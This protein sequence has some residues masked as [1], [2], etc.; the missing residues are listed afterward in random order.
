VSTSTTRPSYTL[1]AEPGLGVRP[2]SP[3]E[4]LDAAYQGQAGAYSERAARRLCGPH[5]ALLPC[6]TLADVFLAVREGRARSGVVPIENTLTGAVPGVVSLLLSSGMVVAAEAVESIDHVLAAPPGSRLGDVRE[7][8]SHPVALAQCTRFFRSH[9]SVRAVPVFDTAGAL[10]MVMKEGASGKAAIAS[11]WAAEL[12]GAAVLADHLQDHE[13]NFT[14]FLQVAPA[15]LTL[16]PAEEPAHVVIGARL[17]HE[18]GTLARLLHRLAESGL[19]L[20]RIDSAPIHGSPFEYEFLLEG[21]APAGWELDASG[22]RGE[23]R[24]IGRFAHDGSSS[25]SP[26]R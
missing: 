11:R 1:A 12:Y 26:P 9:P 6:E 10:D 15:P 20:T 4:P 7:V 3:L 16:A 23:C 25:T 24:V 2:T 14:R 18:P 17:A 8:L 19:N 13:A 5:A 22:L 21:T